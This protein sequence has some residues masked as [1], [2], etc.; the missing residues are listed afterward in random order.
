LI[1]FMAFFADAALPSPAGFS[2]RCAAQLWRDSARCE[3]DGKDGVMIWFGYLAS[4]AA[5]VYFV[6]LG[7]L[8]VKHLLQWFHK[9]LELLQT[10]Q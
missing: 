9:L 1:V 6:L 10:A 5:T 4:V 8:I 2:A 3:H 7:G